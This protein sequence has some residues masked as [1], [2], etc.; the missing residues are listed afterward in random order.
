MERVIGLVGP[1]GGMKTRAHHDHEYLSVG[2]RRVRYSRSWLTGPVGSNTDLIVWPGRLKHRLD[3]QPRRLPLLIMH[4][5]V[6]H[7]VDTPRLRAITA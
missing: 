5:L 4:L 6:R 3:H 7:A 1:P 2:F